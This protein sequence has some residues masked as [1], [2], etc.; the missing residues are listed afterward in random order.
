SGLSVRL[1]HHTPDVLGLDQI[2]RTG[3]YAPPPA[4]VSRLEALGPTF[5][6]RTSARTSA[7]SGS[8][9]S[10]T[11]RAHGSPPSS[12]IDTTRGCFAGASQQMP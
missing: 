11:F 10:S 4:A 2:F 5:E 7:C 8:M 1:R 12:R 6:S 9:S 3:L